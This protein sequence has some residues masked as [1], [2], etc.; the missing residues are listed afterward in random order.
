MKPAEH[1]AKQFHESYERLA[2]SHDY[3]TRQASAKP[4]EQVPEPNKAL[5]IAVAADLLERGIITVGEA[6][7]V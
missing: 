2:P 5:M 7:N 6:Q 1:V 3:R 4:W